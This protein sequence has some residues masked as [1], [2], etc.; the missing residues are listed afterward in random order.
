[1][2]R[3]S[4]GASTFMAVHEPFNE[5]PWIESVTKDGN[6]LIIRYKLDGRA[7]EDRVILDKDGEIQVKSSA[8]WHYNAGAAISGQVKA[9]EVSKGA[10]R[11]QLDRDA[12]KVNYVRLDLAEGVTKY[13]P[14]ASVNGKWLELIADPGF[15]MEAGTGKVVFHSFPQEQY[16][17]PLRYTLFVK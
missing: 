10:W 4:G 15:T 17:G 6:A 16:P 11:I 13:Y 9:L 1:M 3:H 14:V 2:Q 8:G 7:V 5:K 12:P